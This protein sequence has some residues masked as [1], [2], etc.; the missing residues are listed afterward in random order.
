MNH[1]NQARIAGASHPVLV[2]RVAASAFLVRRI[3]HNVA[4][5]ER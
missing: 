3:G 5:L 2:S 4:A 1:G